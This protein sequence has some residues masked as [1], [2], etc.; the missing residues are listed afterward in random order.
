MENATLKSEIEMLKREK[1][2]DNADLNR[3]IDQNKK[4]NLIF[5]GMEISN[6]RADVQRL[7]SEKLGVNGVEVM[8]AAKLFERRGRATVIA[9]FGTEDAA[10]KILKN[11]YKLA[12]TS[13]IIEKDLNQDR[14]VKKQIMLQ[15]KKSILAI[16]N[17]YKILV[18]DDKLKIDQKWFRY[19]NKNEFVCNMENGKEIIDKM[20]NGNAKNLN[21]DY[22]FM[23]DVIKNSQISKN[24]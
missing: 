13:I 10:F 22:T 12:G 3:L 2:Q 19:N 11:S 9:D 23:L 7:C 14:R 8:S 6:P 21:F 5:K 15:I 20:Y 1:R 17:T 16:D 4:K 18:R 24:F